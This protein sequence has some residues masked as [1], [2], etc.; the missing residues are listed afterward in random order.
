MEY[1]LIT[2]LDETNRGMAPIIKGVFEYHEVAV[3]EHDGALYARRSDLLGLS[4][5]VGL[6]WE[7]PESTLELPQ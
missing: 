6:D 2:R 4:S 5:E 3:V 7:V 1:C